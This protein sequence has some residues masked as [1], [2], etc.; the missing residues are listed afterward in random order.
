MGVNIV[1]GSRHLGGFVGYGAAEE[2]W[3][4]KK[5]EGWVESLR[6]LAEVS[7]KHLQYAYA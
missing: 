2:I 3:L 7:R 4:A 6:T 5:V 1:T